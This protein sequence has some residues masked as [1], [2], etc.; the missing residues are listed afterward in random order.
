MTP[1]RNHLLLIA[2]CLVLAAGT[3]AAYW[4]LWQHEFINYDDPLYVT[5]NPRVLEGLTFQNIRWAFTSGQISNWHPLTWLSLMLDSSLFSMNPAGFHATNLL[6]H[7]ANTVLLFLVLVRLSGRIGPSL[8]AAAL[9]GLHPLHVESVAWISERKDV[10]STL[11]WMLTMLCYVRYARKSSPFAY[12][13]MMVCFAMGLMAKPMLVTLPFVLLLIDYWPLERIKRPAGE[14]PLAPGAT[15]RSFSHLI[16]EKIPLFALSAV[17]SVVTFL[18]QREGGAVAKLEGIP[19]SHRLTNAVV[20]YTDYIRQ[21]FWPTD[22]SV[23][24]PHPQ[25]QLSVFTVLFSSLVLL[26]VTGVVIW[27]F[28]RKPYLPVGWFWYVGTLV[29]VIGLVQV[30]AQARADRYTYV[31][32]TGLFIMLAWLVGDFT[33]HR[34][35]ARRMAAIAGVSVCVVLG[36]CT[37]QQSRIWQGNKTLFEQAIKTNSKNYMALNELGVH[38]AET[39]DITQAIQYFRATLAIKPNDVEARY[40][41]GKALERTGKTDEAAEHFKE[42]LRIKPNDGDI[43]HTLA[44]A[45]FEKGNLEQAEFLYRNGLAAAPNDA[46]LHSGLGMVLLYMGKTDPAIQEMETAIEIGGDSETF[47]NLAIA[48][49]SKGQK[50]KANEYLKKAIRLDPYNAQAYFNMGNIE[51]ADHSLTGAI[52]QY[53]KAIELKPDYVKAHGNLAVALAQAGRIDE[54]IVHFKKV[55]ELD[56]ENIDSHLNLAQALGEKGDIAGVVE[57]LRKLVELLP[58]NADIRCELADAL[59]GQGHPEEAVTWYKR[60]LELD[61]KHSR[62]LRGLQKTARS[63]Q[64]Q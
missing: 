24:Y 16:L 10:L 34:P 11:F 49:L 54:A 29:P 12:G 17:S 46:K 37:Y 18:V 51:L 21:M 33:A 53:K 15:A 9:F 58:N 50:D 56:P 63:G 14:V 7:A 35:W 48:V 25:G 55:A 2:L 32:L 62:A 43:Y 42:V 28:R 40:N 41:L 61:P 59:L 36:V 60:A 19:W 39:G 5:E 13:F 22:L 44:L 26:A 20:S 27:Q 3:V 38:C 30:G 8:L 1:D 45:E 47:C 64:K 4:G 31:P 57:Q 6:L 23:F 52:D